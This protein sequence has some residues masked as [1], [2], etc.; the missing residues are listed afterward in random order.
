MEKSLKK[1]IDTESV[2]GK[3]ELRQLLQQTSSVD[4]YSLLMN[5]RGD[6]YSGIT[7][8]H[9]AA[10]YNDLKTMKYMLEGFTTDEKYD[11]LKIQAGDGLSA[12]HYAAVGG[13]SSIITYLL[14]D[15][16]QQQKYDLLQLQKIDGNTPLHRAASQ[17]QS[18]AVQ[19][20]LTSLS[21]PLLLQLLS[22]KNHEDKTAADIRP[23][24]YDELPVQA[25]QGIV[26]LHLLQ[27]K[28][29]Q[30]CKHHPLC[31]SK[32]LTCM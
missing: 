21:L 1:Y 28:Y 3:E 17:H 25:S 32:K 30:L 27:H 7:G 9:I 19:T 14:T 11:V 13:Y 31:A 8:P 23:E 18:E 26:M 12:L 29:F 6:K 22:I 24:I 16:S 4:R 15:L 2:D 5:V 20:I 10:L